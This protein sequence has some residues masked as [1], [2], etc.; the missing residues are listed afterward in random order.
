MQKKIEIVYTSRGT[1]GIENQTRYNTDDLL[2]IANWL[3][4]HVPEDRAPL[5]P[6]GSVLQ[7]ID[8]RHTV[9]F[10]TSTLWVSGE[11]QTTRT[12]NW[13]SP[14]PSN[15]WNVVQIVPPDRLYPNP[16]EALAWEGE[17]APAELVQMVF[18]RL[19]REISLT[20]TVKA[21]EDR[22]DFRI[23]INKEAGSRKRGA[24]R[25]TERVSIGL[26]YARAGLYGQSR[27]RHMM[28][29]ARYTLEKAGRTL[30]KVDPSLMH[31]ME[32]LS[33]EMQKVEQAAD[34][35]GTKLNELMQLASSR[36]YTTP[37]A[38]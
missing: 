20:W 3:E 28:H 21:A 1:I 13:V 32:A 26:R 34:D 29:W 33:E 19:D 24:D 17:E 37:K 16:I 7:F 15:G 8:W 4:S 30:G 5:R 18:V 14:D 2:A 9:P 10:V 27:G 35:L 31:E 22:P 23:R 12:P 25:R 36:N 6:A 11:R 38:D